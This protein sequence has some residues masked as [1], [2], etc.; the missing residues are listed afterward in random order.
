M[1]PVTQNDM[2][3]S[4][5]N[6]IAV[7]RLRDDGANWPDYQSKART[8]MGARGLIRH[9]DG[10]ARKPIAYPEVNGVPMKKPGVEATD[11]ELEEK[12][13]KLDEYEQKEYGAQHVM[14]TTV[15]PRLATLIKSKTAS[16]MWSAICNDATKKSQLHKVDTRRRLQSMVCDKDGDIKAHLNTMIRLREEL[17]GI[18]TSV[19]DKDFGTMLLT[20]LLPSYCTLLHTTTHAASLSGMAINPNDL[21]RI[22]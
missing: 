13:K 14:L 8:A 9:V 4:S 19:Q 17:E 2:P 7:P 6:A 1:R 15:S 5:N 21:M 3:N 10:T 20:S 18:G 11:D 22:V 12:E 16:E